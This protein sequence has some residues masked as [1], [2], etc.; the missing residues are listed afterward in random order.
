MTTLVT[1][2]ISNMQTSLFVCSSNLKYKN[3]YMIRLAKVH[4]LRLP[5]LF[6][7]NAVFTAICGGQRGSAGG[8]FIGGQ[9]QGD[10]WKIAVV[11][12]GVPRVCVEKLVSPWPPRSATRPLIAVVRGSRQKT[13]ELY[14][15][16]GTFVIIVCNCQNPLTCACCTWDYSLYKQPPSNYVK[17]CN[18]MAL[19][20]FALEN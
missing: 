8:I 9:L 18:M 11:K 15:N 13:R 3:I 7:Q 17:F 20:A 4:K 10:G 12:R 6:L 14:C 1:N 5:T 16:Y 19:K 2:A